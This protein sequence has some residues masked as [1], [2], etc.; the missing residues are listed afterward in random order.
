MV[1]LDVQKDEIMIRQEKL[2]VYF[3][4]HNIRGRFGLTF[5]QFVT[6]VDQGSWEKFIKERQP[7][8]PG[9][10]IRG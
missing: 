7:Q 5:Q 3:K 10:S 9:Q 6:K 1:V 4:H 2:G 8:L